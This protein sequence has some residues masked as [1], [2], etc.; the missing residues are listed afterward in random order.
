MEHNDSSKFPDAAV[1]TI[2]TAFLQAFK[3]LPL[4]AR[5]RFLEKVDE[6]NVPVTRKERNRAERLAKF[7]ERQRQAKEEQQSELPK[8]QVIH[9]G[10]V[11]PE[12]AKPYKATSNIVSS[13]AVFCELCGRYHQGNVCYSQ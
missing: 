4:Q 7:K 10:I 5:V 6:L 13:G 2:A 3:A 11:S 1:E 9:D 12:P 8:E